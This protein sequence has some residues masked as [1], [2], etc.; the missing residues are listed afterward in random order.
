[1]AY[2]P[3]NDIMNV[4]QVSFLYGVK[5]I[6]QGPSFI[7]V[8]GMN[9]APDG[10]QPYSFDEP[11]PWELAIVAGILLMLLSLLFADAIY[12]ATAMTRATRVF[13]ATAIGSVIGTLMVPLITDIALWAKAKLR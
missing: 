11:F 4:G 12:H 6:D 9:D 3:N 10:Q 2:D 13:G 8:G 1:M 7:I 5:V